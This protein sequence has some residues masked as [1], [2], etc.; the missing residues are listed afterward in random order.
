MDQNGGNN[1]ERKENENTVSKEA[2][3]RRKPPFCTQRYL[4]FIWAQSSSRKRHVSHA[5]SFK[6]N[7]KLFL[8][9]FRKI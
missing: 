8:M 3:D 2:C 1:K 9:I 4:I 7:M 6:I 5:K